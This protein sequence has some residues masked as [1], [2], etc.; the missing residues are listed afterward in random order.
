MNFICEFGIHE[1][2]VYL[3]TLAPFHCNGWGVPYAVTGMGATH[4]IIRKI[5][6]AEFFKLVTEE[7]VTLAC[8]PPTMINAALNHPI[9]EAT[10]RRMPPMRIGTANG[11]NSRGAGKIRLARHSNLRAHGDLTVAH[12]LERQADDAGIIRRRK[13]AL[14]D[15]YR[16]P[17]DRR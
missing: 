3:H 5:E 7:Q 6:P 14:A 9:D 12:S 13:I 16:L 17:D 1:T 2:D 10:R 8:M 15:E 4:V 11:N